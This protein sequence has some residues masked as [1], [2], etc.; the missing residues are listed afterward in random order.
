MIPRSLR[1]FCSR[2]FPPKPIVKVHVVYTSPQQVLN[3]VVI[4]KSSATIAQV[5]KSD[6][7]VRI[8]EDSTIVSSTDNP[9]IKDYLI[10]E[11]A[12]GFNL[13]HMDNTTII[14]SDV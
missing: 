13:I 2:Q 3:G 14:T 9:N 1:T 11:D 5:A 12:A 10:A 4:Q 6:M 8:I 7:E